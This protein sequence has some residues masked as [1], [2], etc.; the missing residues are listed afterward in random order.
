MRLEKR[1]PELSQSAAFI[2]NRQTHLYSS[3]PAPGQAHPSAGNARRLSNC[4]HPRLSKAPRFLQGDSRVLNRT[5]SAHKIA[6]NSVGRSCVTAKTVAKWVSRYRIEGPAGL[7]DRSSRPRHSPRRTPC[8]LA[9]A[10][11]EQRRQYRPAYQIAQT[12]AGQDMSFGRP[13]GAAGEV[14][15]P[16]RPVAA[17]PVRGHEIHSAWSD[18]WNVV[19]SSGT[20]LSTS[21]SKVDQDL[22]STTITTRLDKENS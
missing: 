10:V 21:T 19:R 16:E 2:Y 5:H 15:P 1:N 8:P 11:L 18:R 9:T 12:T 7:L 4:G 14:E 6:G 22:T 13:V 3:L 17:R 20:P